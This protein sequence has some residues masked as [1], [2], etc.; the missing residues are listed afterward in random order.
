[1]YKGTMYLSQTHYTEEILRT[2]QF[3]ECHSS[4]HINTAQHVPQ[5]REL[6]WWQESC[7]GFP[8]MLEWYCR[9]S[10]MSCHDDTPRPCWG[11]FQ[12]QQVC[13]ISRKKHMLAAEHVLCYL[14]GTWNQTNCYFRDS[15]E[16]PN[17]LWGW[18]DAHWA[19]DTDTLRTHTGY[20]LMMNGGPIFWKSLHQDNVSIA[21]SEDGFVTVSQAG[22]EAIYLCVTLTDLGFLRLKPLRCTK[23]TLL[24]LRW[25]KIQCA[26][27]SHVILI[28]IS[29]S[30]NFSCLYI[31]N[32]FVGSPIISLLKNHYC[33]RGRLSNG[34][35]KS[36][37]GE[38]FFWW[39]LVIW[40][41]PN[42]TWWR[43]TDTTLRILAV[44][45]ILV[46]NR[47]IWLIKSPK[48]GGTSQG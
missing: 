41:P 11:I 21:N 44:R 1:M 5:Q 7:P 10:R 30:C 13:A 4:P 34:Y 36:R 14:C 43:D 29:T 46:Q 45:D 18:V 20:I 22:Q 19:G 23:T 28:F 48:S 27:S 37:L 42:T 15:H 25:A 8:S 40:Q 26:E 33:A 31:D 32:F 12:A 38:C 9:Q 24:V 16:N 35:A 39:T 17:V 47:N 6:P 3:L 2:F